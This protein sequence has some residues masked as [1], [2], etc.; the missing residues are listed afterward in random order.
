MNELKSY[1]ELIKLK[2]YR[3][4]LLYLSL[5]G[6]V[7]APTFAGHRYLNQKFYHSSEWRRF[8]RSIIIRDNGC[9]LAL[10]QFEIINGEP[11]YIH[12]L[13]PITIDDLIHVRPCVLD[14]ENAVCVTFTTHQ[15]IHY[16]IHDFNDEIVERKKNDTCPWRQ[17]K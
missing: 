5:S 11:I 15:L 9:D 14:P 6:K 7:G 12:H 10:P 16:G 13:N 8:K 2:T 17:S 3:E 1:S 4:R